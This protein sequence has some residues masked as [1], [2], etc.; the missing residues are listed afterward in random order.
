MDEIVVGRL[1]L[2]PHRAL[3]RLNLLEEGS[4]THGNAQDPGAQ[5][6]LD[7]ALAARA[8]GD[9]VDLKPGGE[10]FEEIRHGNALPIGS[11][12]DAER[13]DKKPL[14]ALI[15]RRLAR[16]IDDFPEP[17]RGAKS[18]VL[19]ALPSRVV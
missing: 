8:H 14:H 16:P 9:D 7:E 10:R 5:E 2:T 6:P 19:L 12:N 13:Y 17:P 3:K 18:A 11:R 1:E 4:M 15:R